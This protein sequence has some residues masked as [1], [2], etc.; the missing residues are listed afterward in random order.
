MSH[1]RNQVAL[2]LRQAGVNP[3]RLC[4]HA[5]RYA[6]LACKVCYRSGYLA[7]A[8]ADRVVSHNKP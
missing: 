6:V 7:V 4:L 8:V 5:W 3:Q 1:Y 2:L